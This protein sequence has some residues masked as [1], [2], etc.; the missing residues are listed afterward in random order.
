[1]SEIFCCLSKTFLSLT[2]W[3]ESKPCPGT[4]SLESKSFS[5]KS[6]DAWTVFRDLAEKQRK[7]GLRKREKADF[8]EYSS[9]FFEVSEMSQ[10]ADSVRETETKKEA[11]MQGHP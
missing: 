1:M 4:L 7:K 6:L 11:G 8:K 9:S 3:R 10:P 5:E 2:R